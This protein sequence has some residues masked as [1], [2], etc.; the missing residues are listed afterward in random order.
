MAKEKPVFFDE[1]QKVSSRRWDQLEADPELAAPW[2]QLFTQVQSPRH[3]LS[4]LLQN[5]DDAE[6]T[7]VAV[8]LSDEYFI[9][10]HNGAD[11][12]KENLESICKFGYSNK[13]KMHTI[14]FRGIGFKSTFSL[15]DTVELRTPSLSISFHKNR[16]TQPVWVEDDEDY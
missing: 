5:A 15:G 4:E 16:F 12:T 3:V 10:T 13:R 14:G 11:F 2:H 7:E 8:E 1:I 6:A 9:F